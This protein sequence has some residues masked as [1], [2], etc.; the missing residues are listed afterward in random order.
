MLIIKCSRRICGKGCY[1][2][3]AIDKLQPHP[4]NEKIYG[5]GNVDDLTRNIQTFGWKIGSKLL[6]TESL[7]IVGGHRRW[8]AAKQLGFTEIPVD[9]DFVP[10]DLAEQTLLEDNEGRIKTNEQKARECMAW[11]PI[12]VA[13]AKQRQDTGGNSHAVRKIFS[14]AQN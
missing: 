5:D 12:E 4:Q 13:K 11:E 2:R 3:I 10:E 9:E 8:K 14:E 1:M 7:V 6:V